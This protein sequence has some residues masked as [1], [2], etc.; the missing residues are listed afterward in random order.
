MGIGQCGRPPSRSVRLGRGGAPVVLTPIIFRWP[1][2]SVL[3]SEPQNSTTASTLS[4]LLERIGAHAM[5]CAVL[6]GVREGIHAPALPGRA[7][8]Q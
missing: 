4:K 5:G 7:S 3:T 2:L 8:E 6:R 1:S